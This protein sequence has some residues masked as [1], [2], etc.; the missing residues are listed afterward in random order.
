MRGR[1]QGGG[2]PQSEPLALRKSAYVV[3]FHKIFPPRTEERIIFI[4][5]FVDNYLVNSVTNVYVTLEHHVMFFNVKNLNYH[6]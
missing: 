1:R 3:V 2:G 4:N 5:L 6:I